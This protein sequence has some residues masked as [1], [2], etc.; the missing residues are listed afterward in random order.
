MIFEIATL[1]LSGVMAKPGGAPGCIINE[2]VITTGMGPQTPTLGYTIKSTVSGPNT[3]TFTVVNPNRQ[4]FQ[5]IL[6]YVANSANRKIRLGKF[7]SMDMKKFKFQNATTC[8]KQGVTGDP[9]ATVTH[10]IPARVG[11][12]TTFTWTG[13]AEEMNGKDNN[14]F[15]VIASLDPGATGKAK[16][17]IVPPV[18]LHD[19]ADG[20]N[21]E[22]HGSTGGTGGS[23]GTGG[24]TGGSGSTG[25]GTSSQASQTAISEGYSSTMTFAGGLTAFLFALL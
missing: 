21:H 12:N 16:W 23:S 2:T 15:A 18:K 14:L 22:G 25:T 11:L 9:S 6:M 20:H 8:Q 5:G 1:L 4:D 17:Q 13:T 10:A 3:M 19:D 24:S 7:T